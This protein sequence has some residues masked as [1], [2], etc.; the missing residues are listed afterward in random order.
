MGMISYIEYEE[1]LKDQLNKCSEILKKEEVKE[2]LL[3]VS[4]WDKTSLLWGVGKSG[5]QE[6]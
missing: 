3:K 2:A 5:W 1:N 6:T 4:N